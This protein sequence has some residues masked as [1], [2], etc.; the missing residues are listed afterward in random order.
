MVYYNRAAGTTNGHNGLGHTGFLGKWVWPGKPLIIMT[1]FAI[2]IYIIYIKTM[3]T[4]TAASSSSK[5]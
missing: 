2:Y 3:A 4:S 1:E 5:N